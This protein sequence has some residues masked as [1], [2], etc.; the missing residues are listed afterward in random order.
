MLYFTILWRS[1][2]VVIHT[3]SKE[4]RFNHF[5]RSTHKSHIA[6][7]LISGPFCYHY[8]KTLT[9]RITT[10]QDSFTKHFRLINMYFIV[11]RKMVVAIMLKQRISA[12]IFHECLKKNSSLKMRTFTRIYRPHLS[13][14]IV[15][16]TCGA[17]P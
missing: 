4:N 5:T 2:Y 7:G 1:D 14:R 11:K 12:E 13:W 10:R 17:H 3:R 9:E 8:C 16:R 6:L 15:I